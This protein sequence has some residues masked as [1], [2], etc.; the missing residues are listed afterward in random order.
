MPLPASYLFILRCI[1]RKENLALS[2]LN[3]ILDHLY[4]LQKAILGKY[5][6]TELKMYNNPMNNLDTLIFSNI[7]CFFWQNQG[8]I[9]IL[10]FLSL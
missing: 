3:K 9:A 7:I 5:M 10:F 6:S 2:Y 1:F 8:T 4:I